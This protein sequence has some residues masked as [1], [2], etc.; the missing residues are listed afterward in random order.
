MLDAPSSEKDQNRGSAS[1]RRHK[2]IGD[3][4]RRVLRELAKRVAEIAALPIQAERARLWK[5]LNRRSPERAMVLAQTGAIMPEV[6]LRC[7]EPM[8]RQWEW[9]LRWKLHRYE[10][11][12]DDYPCTDFLDIRYAVDVSDYGVKE[13]R[14]YGEID[15]FGAYKV[16]PTINSPEDFEKLRPRRISVDHEATDRRV[17]VAEEVLGDILHVRKQ[18]ETMCRNMLTRKLIHLRGFDQ[19]LLDMY[20]NPE[21]LHQMMAFLRDET[22]REWEIY[23][24]EGALSLNSGP[25][26]IRGTGGVAYTDELPSQ[27]HNGHVRMRDMVCF[28]DSQESVGVGPEFFNEFVLQYQLPL[29][30]CF[31]QVD[32]GCCEPQDGKFDLLFEHIPRLCSVSVHP[33]GNREEAAEKLADR[34]VYAYKPHPGVLEL[35]EPDYETAERELRETLEIA[36]GCCVSLTMKADLTV[37]TA[38]RVVRWTDIAQRVVAEVA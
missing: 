38:D 16:N 13:G 27:D 28:G 11:I 26:D 3:E 30:N 22:L 6:E 15:G 4:D 36:A 17:E 5:A 25:D 35:P 23:E 31:G 21:L 12:H 37:D 29:M 34:Y 9:G 33:W 19:F 2:R 7:E 14:I 24:R 18:G 8:C 1:V 10:H 32:Y 20:D